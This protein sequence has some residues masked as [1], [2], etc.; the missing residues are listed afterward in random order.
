[1]LVDSTYARIQSHLTHS[2]NQ[3]NF[4]NEDIQSLRE[5]ML[6]RKR[7]LADVEKE[8]KKREEEL[9]KI[10]TDEIATKTQKLINALKRNPDI[11]R[12]GRYGSDGIEVMTHPLFTKIRTADGS[13]VTK[14]RC[15]G[16]YRIRIVRSNRTFQVVNATF[17]HLYRQ[18]WGVD[19]ESA[20]L[21]NWEP[22]YKELL[23]NN[24]WVGLI[25]MVILYLKD[26]QD[27]GA[28]MRS[29]D[30]V[31]DRNENNFQTTTRRP[32]LAVGDAV[33]GRSSNYLA[34]VAELHP[35]DSKYVRLTAYKGS[36]QGSDWHD[37]KYVYKISKLKYRFMTNIP[38]SEIRAWAKA[39]E[40][41]EMGAAS[42]ADMV[43]ALKDGVTNEEL[44]AKIKEH[45]G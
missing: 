26:T 2:I 1:M 40:D 5:R 24:D 36:S 34:L 28:Y 16:A 45:G 15:L 22:M 43:D 27:S 44:L 39:K 11:A 6:D 10:N 37:S 25:C 30:W 35:D 38:Y 19:S 8:Q 33:I 18:H 23:A 41:K 29:H 12:V 20:C 7:Q 42:I 9:T 21:G 3:R 14:R 4:I 17:R 13:K 31:T 32:R